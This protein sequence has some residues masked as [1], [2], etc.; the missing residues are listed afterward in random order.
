MSGHPLEEGVKKD[1]APPSRLQDRYRLIERLG[2][3]SMGIVYRARDET[4]GRD[5]AIKF[6]LPERV[7][8][9]EASARFLREARAV[10]HEDMVTEVIGMQGDVIER[11]DIFEFRQTGVEDG[12]I[13]GHLIDRHRAH[14]QVSG[15]HPGSGHRPAVESLYATIEEC[16]SLPKPTGKLPAARHLSFTRS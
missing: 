12:K 15:S 13:K 10:A 9:R 11:Q 14:S 3:G 2:E 5:A 1:T 7:A 16:G 4:L 8:G 6:L